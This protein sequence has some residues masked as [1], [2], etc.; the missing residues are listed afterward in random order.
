MTVENNPLKQY[1]RRPAIY[2]KLP[3]G[4]K[5]YPDGVINMP[6]SGELPVYPMTAIDEIT[7]KTPDALFNGTAI[8]ELIQSCVPNILDPWKISSVDLDAILIAVKA[9]A[10]GN[11][12][13]IVSICPE[14]KQDAKY[15]VNLV[16]LL[17]T[18]KSGD[19]AQELTINELL[20]KFRPLTY[21]EMNKA[22]I[23]QFDLQRTFVLLEGITDLDEKNKK[24][25]E[26][27]KTITEVTMQVLSNTIE[28]IKTPSAF[29]DNNNFILD[30]LQNCDKN[31]YEQ[32]KIHNAE[33]KQQT[34][35]KPLKIKCIACSHE[36][37]Q[38]FTLNTSDFFD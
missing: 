9:A 12:L 19:Y 17:T 34:E 13:E 11:D 5:S 22:S 29:V 31:I 32:I 20:I 26:A 2:L 7:T 23:A 30:F 10:G 16:S 37:T 1:F 14:C 38:A 28:Y 4:G 33:L 21:A 36:Y 35:I 18:L 25:K 15:G 24:S 27:L 8:V 3:S 6:E